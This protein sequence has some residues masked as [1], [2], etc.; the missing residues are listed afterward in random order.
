M[1]KRTTLVT[2][3]LILIGLIANAQKKFPGYFNS[4]AG[5][6]MTFNGGW[7]VT[8]GNAYWLY[9]EN[10]IGQL[11]I[12][13]GVNLSFNWLIN[14]FNLGNKNRENS[15]S[16][17][18]IVLTPMNVFGFGGRKNKSFYQEI[19]TFN[20]AQSNAMA[21][22]NKWQIVIGSNFI[23]SPK[24]NVDNFRARL[25]EENLY[26]TKNRSQQLFFISAR[27]NIKWGYNNYSFQIMHYNDKIVLPYLLQAYAD[28]Y[29][30]YNTGGIKASISVYRK[31][32]D[33]FIN[34]ISFLYVRDIYTGGFERDLFDNPDL[35]LPNEDV[36]MN[37]PELVRHKRIVSQEPGEKMLN[38]GRSFLQINI[39]LQK[40]IRPDQPAHST[41]LNI[42][43]GMQ[44]GDIGFKLQDKNHNRKII[45]KV[46][47]RYDPS[48]LMG[49]K[50]DDKKTLERL[51]HFDPIN[52]YGNFAFGVGVGQQL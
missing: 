16:Q 37:K 4:K 51:H 9:K 1:K 26:T 32:E 52:K 29:D 28:G 48:I 15:R 3:F 12:Q 13:P 50:G 39:P 36:E 47:P 46:N 42:Y 34:P 7:G 19:A 11:D 23:L 24:S 5:M 20:V 40:Y 25:N 43:A 8:F 18:N 6:Y 27:G 38:R 31:K 21:S 22:N 41:S 35:Y 2:F 14:Q 45:Y 30:R 44:G 17:L 10:F 33:T 49:T